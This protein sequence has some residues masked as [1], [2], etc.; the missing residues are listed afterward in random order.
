MTYPIDLHSFP[1]RDSLTTELATTITA[2]LNQGITQNDRA[3]LAVS[4]GSTPV[5]LFECLSAM[6]LPW[7]KV[8][9]LLVDERWVSPIDLDSNEHLVKK[10]L[11]QNRAKAANFT[12]MW[13]SAKTASE[14]EEKCGTQLQKIHRPFD[15]L[16]LGMGGDGHTASLFPGAAKLPLATDM[17]SGKICMGIAPISAPHERMTLTLPVILESK[18][19]FLH[20]TGQNKKDVLEKALGDGPVEEM[21]I[22][23]ILQN[24]AQKQTMNFSIYWA[25]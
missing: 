18:Q 19:I 1:D 3:S 11:L 16:I 14:G 9:I 5:Q 6:N 7:Q 8:D 10:H 23:F 22:R 4:G 2:L 15:V 25:K 17:D 24:Q 12:G 20:I 21:P 13:N